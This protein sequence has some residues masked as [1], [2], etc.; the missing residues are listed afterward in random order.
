[1]VA[2]IFYTIALVRRYVIEPG[3]R[4][5]TDV[6]DPAAGHDVYIGRITTVEVTAAI[7]RRSRGGSI[8]VA[9]AAAALA[10]FR[11]DVR[12]RYA[13]VGLSDAV[14]DL[15]ADCAERHGLRAYDAVQ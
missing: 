6:L 14:A 11:A 5:V 13:I 3:S 10:Q 7:A 2:Y 15:A 4:W 9:N 12:G 8:S 1:M